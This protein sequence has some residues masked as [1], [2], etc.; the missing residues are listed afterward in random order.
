MYTFTIGHLILRIIWIISLVATT[1]YS[2]TWDVKMDW[3]FF[4]KN[5]KNKFLRNDLIFPTWVGVTP[6]LNMNINF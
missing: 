5:S 2:Y 1:S 6:I 4:K 3:G